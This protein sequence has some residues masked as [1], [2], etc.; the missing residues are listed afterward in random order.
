M[1]DHDETERTAALLTSA[2]RAAA[3]VMVVHEAPERQYAEQ[4]KPARGRWLFPLA[5]AASVVL[6][7]LGA[8]FAAHPSSPARMRPVDAPTLVQG[9]AQT[10]RPEFYMTATYPATG[11]NVLQ[12][13]VRRTDGGAVTASR[14]I[15]ASGLG[16]GGHLT[17]AA[18]DRAFY[19][20]R[21]PCTTSAV[22]LTTFYRITITSSGQIS[23]FAPVGTPVE[24]MVTTL[25]V[26]PDGS[27]M[28]YNAL[29]GACAGA[30]F[31][32]TAAASV[33]V[34]DLSTGAVR[35]WIS[36]VQ[37][38]PDMVSELSWATNGRTLI[39][40][41]DPRGPWYADLTVYGLDTTS[42]GGVLQ[43]HSTILLRQNTPCSPCVV[44]A[45]AGP[46]G[47]LTELESQTVGQRT[48]VMVVSVPPTTGG[49]QLVLYTEL[50]DAV[51]GKRV[52][53]S[54]L[55]ADSSGQWV[56]LW[57]TT[58]VLDQRD[59][60]VDGWISDGRLHSLL[61]VGDVSPQGIAW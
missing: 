14:S 9:T 35:T 56:L 54:A 26:S 28:A 6:I 21:Y 46:D 33:S 38:A 3:D 58:S 39:V 51:L 17:A 29:S 1:N 47:G 59:F 24:G 57:P 16:W 2:L 8:V 45:L 43:A 20:A 13:Q 44:N 50:I 15:S 42:S 37:M 36:R 12:F 32:S 52:N 48:R 23:G 5:T 25:A 4:V 10:S 61:G 22:P 40:D 49:P 60:A 30:E 55:I 7:A 11:P 53:D 31:K 41:E 27:Q 18:D 19:F 34:L